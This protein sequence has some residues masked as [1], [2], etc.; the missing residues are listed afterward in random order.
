M[1][2]QKLQILIFI[3]LTLQ[4]YHLKFYI[5][6]SPSKAEW[7]RSLMWEDRN[8]EKGIWMRKKNIPLHQIWTSKGNFLMLWKKFVSW[9][10]NCVPCWKNIKI[11]YF[12]SILYPKYLIYLLVWDINRLTA[13]QGNTMK[14][15]KKGEGNLPAKAPQQQKKN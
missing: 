10:R 5:I 11:V 2:G 6:V 4:R 1:C 3:E 14:R 12:F 9:N 13:H 7:K 15:K 8:L